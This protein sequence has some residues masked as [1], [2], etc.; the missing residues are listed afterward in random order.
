M[1]KKFGGVTLGKLSSYDGVLWVYRGKPGE[2]TV[3]DMGVGE[4]EDAC[5]ESRWEIFGIHEFIEC[6]Q[7]LTLQGFRR[8]PMLTSTFLKM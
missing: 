6:G 8:P 3:G 1:K 5:R 4:G 2:Y 7:V